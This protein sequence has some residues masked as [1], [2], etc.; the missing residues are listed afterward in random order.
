MQIFFIRPFRMLSLL[1]AMNS[2]PPRE[3]FPRHL[4]IHSQGG[5]RL[6]LILIL[7]FNVQ[8]SV[9]ITVSSIFPVN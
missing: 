5:Y 6:K 2:S 3:P 7:A 8:P 4:K 1:R 9:D